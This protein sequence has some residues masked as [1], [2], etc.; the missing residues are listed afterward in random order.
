MWVGAGE[1]AQG[2]LWLR[3]FTGGSW[4]E[5]GL[6]DQ[7]Q[8]FQ[9]AMELLVQRGPAHCTEA[10]LSS[11]CV[12]A[13]DARPA[14]Q[15]GTCDP[16]VEWAFTKPLHSPFKIHPKRVTS[17][18]FA[19]SSLIQAST[20]LFWTASLVYPVH[21]VTVPFQNQ[22]LALMPSSLGPGFTLSNLCGFLS[23]PS[24]LLSGLQTPISL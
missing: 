5:S 20:P 24:A 10:S 12:Q 1:A 4:W 18:S 16:W 13:R 17:A 2:W 6:P 22:Q 23:P 3:R 8:A 7:V 14:I 21:G 9:A 15:E 19:A 11:F